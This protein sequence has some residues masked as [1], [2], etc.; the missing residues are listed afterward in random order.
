MALGT[1]FLD[2]DGVINALVWSPPYDYYKQ[3][4]AICQGAE[5]NIVWNTK[6][7]D[8][9]NDVHEKEDIEIVWLTTWGNCANGGLRELLGLPKFRVIEP[10]LDDELDGY[11]FDWWKFKA[12]QEEYERAPEG[13]K[14]AWTDDDL[15]IETKCTQWAA[16]RRI[17]TI[18]P[19]PHAGL[20]TADVDAVKNYLKR[21]DGI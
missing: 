18:Y 2:V 21:K 1:W 9:I 3:G 4:S 8:R 10:P 16:Q 13:Y 12:V 20:A 15:A 6:L 7:I 17:L 14:F 19:R 11:D 5:F